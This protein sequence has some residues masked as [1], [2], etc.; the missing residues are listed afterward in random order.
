MLYVVNILPVNSTE[1]CIMRGK[2]WDSAFSRCDS[3][4]SL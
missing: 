4:Y 1:V 2:V 3:S